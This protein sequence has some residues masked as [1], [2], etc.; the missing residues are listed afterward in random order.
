MSL[1]PP[2]LRDIRPGVFGLWEIFR[3][4]Y[5]G[6]VLIG[7]LSYRAVLTYY[8]VQYLMCVIILVTVNPVST[9][10]R[11][12]LYTLNR[13]Q[14]RISSMLSKSP[15]IEYTYLRV[16]RLC[17]TLWCSQSSCPKFIH[18]TYKLGC[19]SGYLFFATLYCGTGIVNIPLG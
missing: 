10:D 7:I 5:F 19:K 2:S 18:T 4:G 8:H 13:C 6:L 11:Y 17:S 9:Y 14:C 16:P 12:P 3:I 1:L 15:T